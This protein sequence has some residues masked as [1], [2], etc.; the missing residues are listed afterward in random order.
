MKQRVYPYF[1]LTFVLGAVVGVVGFYLYAWYGGHWHRQVDRREF[2]Q[3]LKRELKLDDQQVTQLTQI[4]SES[5]KNYDQ[6]HSQIRPQFDALRDET[7]NQIRQV[8]R[9]D[10]VSRFN[11]LVREWRARGRPPRR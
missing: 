2:V 4:M 10:Q 6:L 3:D 11:E 5:R 8:L 9:P 1:I 7:D